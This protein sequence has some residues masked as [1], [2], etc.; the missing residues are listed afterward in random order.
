MILSGPWKT[1][2]RK[3]YNSITGNILLKKKKIIEET[4][5]IPKLQNLGLTKSLSFM[6][7]NNYSN[8]VASTNKPVVNLQV[9]KKPDQNIEKDNSANNTLL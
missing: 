1:N 7:Y 9:N 8:N 3:F 2:T 5:I 4:L 6:T